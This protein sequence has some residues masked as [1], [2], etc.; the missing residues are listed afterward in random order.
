MSHLR[1]SQL[2]L[3]GPIYII[4]RLVHLILA[5]L[6][7]YTRLA[8]ASPHQIC[9]HNDV[10]EFGGSCRN[11]SS[12]LCGRVVAA[13]HFRTRSY[14]LFHI[15]ARGPVKFDAVLRGG[16]SLTYANRSV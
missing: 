4:S 6:A 14:L 8:T 10:N 7:G 9:L 3:G 12:S 5:A 15:I 13:L 16:H 1:L 11:N 2:K